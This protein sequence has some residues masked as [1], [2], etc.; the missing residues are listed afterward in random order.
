MSTM[1]DYMKVIIS[2]LVSAI[3]TL[4]IAGL[5]NYPS[6]I[7]AEIILVEK[8]ANSYTD[9]A[10]IQHEKVQVKEIETIKT[11]LAAIKETSNNTNQM[12]SKLLDIQLNKK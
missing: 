8:K 9:K 4:L 12:V 5:F 7:K 1:K 3:I 6:K 10:I 11:E 2:A